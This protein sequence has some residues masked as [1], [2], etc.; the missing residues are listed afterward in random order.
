[1]LNRIGRSAIIV[2]SW[3]WLIRTTAVAGAVTIKS[4]EAR[5]MGDEQIRAALE[6]HWLVSPTE[7]WHT[8]VERTHGIY[9]DNVVVEWPQSGERILGL[10]NLR[11]LREAYPAKLTFEIRQIR[12]SGELWVTEYVISYDE[13]PVYTVSIMEFREGKVERETI[14][15]ADPFEAPE[16]R[17]QW[18]ERMNP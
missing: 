8:A 15:F 2:A 6:Q 14:Y 10:G 3:L 13:R 9:N 4:K 18:V 16:W 12:G 11:A 17:S 1:L 5:A 7:D